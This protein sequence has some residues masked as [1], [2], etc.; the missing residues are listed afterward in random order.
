MHRARGA[1]AETRKREVFTALCSVPR[2]PIHLSICSSVHLFICSSVHL[3]RSETAWED[4]VRA[5]NGQWM[6]RFQTTLGHDA[7]TS[8]SGQADASAIRVME[9]SCS[10]PV[11]LV[12]GGQSVCSR[13]GTS[14]LLRVLLRA[15]AC[16]LLV[17]GPCPVRFENHPL[18]WPSLSIQWGPVLTAAEEVQF[19]VASSQSRSKKARYMDDPSGAKGTSFSF[20]AENKVATSDVRSLYLTE[21]TDGSAVNTLCLACVDL[22]QQWASGPINLA[23]M[24]ASQLQQSKNPN[25]RVLK[26]IVHPGEVNKVTTVPNFRHVVAT[27]TDSPEV[28]VWNFNTQANREPGKEKRKGAGVE[29]STPDAVLVGHRE[30]AEFAMGACDVKALLASGGKDTQVLVWY[31]DGARGKGKLGPSVILEG[32]TNT[33]EDVCF[34]PEN[35]HELVSV[36]DDFSMLFWDTRTSTKAVDRVANAHGSKD[37]HSVDWSL[38]TPYLL[39]TG[40]QDGGVYVWDKRNL[41]M[42]PTHKFMHHHKAVTKV[43]WSPHVH[44]VFASGSDDGIVAVWDLNRHATENRSALN[45][46]VPEELIIQHAGHTS[47]VVDFCWNPDDPWT[48]MSA[49]VNSPGTGPMP[50]SG[51][52]ALQFWRVSEMVRCLGFSLR[53]R[54]RPRPRF[55][56]PGLLRSLISVTKHACT[57]PYDATLLRSM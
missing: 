13:V 32:H 29:T 4:G 15:S 56:R 41:G 30:N 33:V 9:A 2:I 52:G 42:G 38:V 7:S 26:T 47:S 28:Y 5:V 1:K 8:P 12:R 27:H 49:S 3:D 51:G 40:A 17:R 37:L 43:E 31:F 39:V 34:K 54:P 36:A 6:K 46:A 11:R 18:V 22:P 35:Q 23:M 55:S 19:G 44:S 14:T 10:I 20:S 50:I 45:M 57:H 24:G 21:Q 25:V 53:L 16:A 48:L